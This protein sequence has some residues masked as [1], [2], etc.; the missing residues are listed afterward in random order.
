ME[1]TSIPANPRIF[2][3]SA[4]NQRNGRKL[5]FR[6]FRSDRKELESH[7]AGL[8]TLISSQYFKPQEI[9]A[10]QWSRHRL[11][12]IKCPLKRIFYYMIQVHF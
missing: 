12:R 2:R 8:R 9:G 11:C 5:E 7:S 4:R 10:N 6:M 1:R 3:N